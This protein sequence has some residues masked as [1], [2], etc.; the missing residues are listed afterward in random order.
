MPR[1]VQYLDGLSRSAMAR[2][3][4]PVALSKVASWAACRLC[5]FA[6]ALAWR[7]ASPLAYLG[8][9]GKPLPSVHN[10]ANSFTELNKRGLECL[11]CWRNGGKEA[12]NYL[13]NQVIADYLTQY[14]ESQW[15]IPSEGPVQPHVDVSRRLAR[16][17]NRSRVPC[18]ANA[19]T[20]SI[21]S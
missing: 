10:A 21:L 6:C 3:V 7:A 19:N 20:M 13:L 14:P 11:A 2:K 17:R 8:A 1:R 4:A 16:T 12:T 18:V 15:P 9:D 5:T